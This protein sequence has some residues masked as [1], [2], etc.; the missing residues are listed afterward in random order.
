MGLVKISYPRSPTHPE[1]GEVGG[2][3]DESDCGGGE[4]T[5]HFSF[6]PASVRFNSSSSEEEL[7]SSSSSSSNSSDVCAFG[8]SHILE[9][10]S[11]LF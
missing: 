3:G 6:D 2:G 4:A 5:A 8:I 11:M 10:S 9:W 1:V 7:E